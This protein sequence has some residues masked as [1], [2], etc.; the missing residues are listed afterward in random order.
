MERWAVF[1]SGSGFWFVGKIA[2]YFVGFVSF[3]PVNGIRGAH[4][5]NG[6]FVAIEANVV[7]DLQVH[8]TVPERSAAFHTFG[9]TNTKIFVD[10]IF[11]I[12]FFNKTAF[13]STGWAKLV[14]GSSSEFIGI[15]FEI[16]A[17]Q[18]AVTAQIEGMKAFD[19][20]RAHHTVG[21]TA[22][23]LGTFKRVDLP[24]VIVFYYFVERQPADTSQSQCQRQPH[25]ALKKFP[26][27]FRFTVFHI[28]PPSLVATYISK[29]SCNFR[30]TGKPN[31]RLLLSGRQPDNLPKRLFL[32]GLIACLLIEKIL[33]GSFFYFFYLPVLIESLQDSSFS[34][35]S[36]RKFH[37][38]LFLFHPPGSY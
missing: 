11:E 20:R 32:Q 29:T 10:V 23:A 33:S 3:H 36:S 9:T 28:S 24:N 17:A 26:P 15:R 34:L 18:I 37:L 12:R 8:R 21:G 27:V 6:A 30:T 19:R 35:V 16:S 1:S 25:P 31:K 14:F 4:A 22:A 2:F 38:R 7:N 13:D 5:G